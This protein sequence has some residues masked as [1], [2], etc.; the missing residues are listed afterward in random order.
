MKKH[1]SADGSWQLD[2]LHDL[3]MEKIALEVDAGR[4]TE[5]E[6]GPA[7]RKVVDEAVPE[8][9]MI[10]LEALRRR[11]HSMLREH[12]SLNRGFA[13]RNIR[14]WRPGFDALEM[15]IVA[16]EEAGEAVNTVQRPAAAANQDYKFEAL[17]GLHGRSVLVAREVYCLMQGG[18]ADGALGRW[19]T[20]HELAVVAN[21]L[22]AHDQGVSERYLLHRTVRMAKAAEQYKE[23][24]QA[25]GLQPLDAAE[26]IELVEAREAIC[27]RHGKAMRED[28]GWAATA[29][30]KDKRITFFDIELAAGLDHWRPRY[31]W[32]SQDTHGNFRP[33]LST[34]AMCESSEQAIVVGPSNS[35]MVDP[36]Q[37]V[38]HGLVMA[39]LPLLMLTPNFD[40]LATMKVLEVLRAEVGDAFVDAEKDSL[41][42]NARGAYWLRDLPGQI[43]ARFRTITGWW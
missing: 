32:A 6:I 1:G 7:M 21:F 19:K 26:L 25:A 23:Y 9:A 11:R 5:A 38:S 36:A 33:S 4:L 40:R 34:L 37:M 17:V 35:G 28:W 14:R 41:E 20:L 27:S 22:L 31:R 24:E 16:C 10:W 13:K 39:T 43:T 8:A 12:R 42:A 2:E 29:L 18:F 15:L 3:L 30:G